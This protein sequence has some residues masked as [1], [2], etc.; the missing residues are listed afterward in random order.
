MDELME[1]MNWCEVS[2]P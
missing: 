2:L 1:W